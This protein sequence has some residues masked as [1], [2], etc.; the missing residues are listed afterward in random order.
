MK[1]KPGQFRASIRFSN[2]IRKIIANMGDKL[3]V[4]PHA[5]KVYDNFYVKR[6]Y[7]CQ[8]FGHVSSECS[9]KTVCGHCAGPHSSWE[10]TVSHDESKKCCINCKNKTDHTLSSTNHAASSFN[11]PVYSQN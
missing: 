6:C 1:K 10:C 3:F 2:M 8:K 9:G 5:C 11:C 4:G 7:K